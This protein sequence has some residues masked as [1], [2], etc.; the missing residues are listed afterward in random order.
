MYVCK[1]YRRNLRK[2]LVAG[3]SGRNMVHY[4]GR[5]SVAEM[6]QVQ[7]VKALTIK[8]ILTSENMSAIEMNLVIALVKADGKLPIINLIENV[9]KANPTSYKF[10][11]DQRFYIA[12]SK[13]A[14]KRIVVYG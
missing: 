13:L 14:K 4:K 12:V 9:R 6:S 7:L 2:K 10:V 3:I 8:D 1:K 11:E 5:R